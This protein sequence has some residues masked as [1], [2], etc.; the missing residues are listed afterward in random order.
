MCFCS[1]DDHDIPEPLSSRLSVP[2][3]ELN[4]YRAAVALRLVLI[5]AFFRYRVTRPVADA[6]ALWVTSVACELW[7]AASWLIAQLPKL[8]PANRVTYLDRL[9][10]RSS[11]SPWPAAM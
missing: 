2:S 11:R 3:G 9:V 10:S 7:L 1:G 4:L 6:H 5:A 8:S